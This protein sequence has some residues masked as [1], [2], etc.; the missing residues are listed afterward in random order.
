MWPRAHTHIELDVVA[1]LLLVK[2]VKGSAPGDEQNGP[3][4]MDRG[5]KMYHGRLQHTA[6]EGQVLPQIQALG[7]YLTSHGGSPQ[8]MVAIHAASTT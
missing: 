4:S 1:L 6:T 2:Q 5:S 3:A 7:G 8:S